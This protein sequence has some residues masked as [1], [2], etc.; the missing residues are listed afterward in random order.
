MENLK[1]L[2]Q[3]SMFISIVLS[4]YRTLLSAHLILKIVEKSLAD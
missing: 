4:K 1:L 3:L 2:K